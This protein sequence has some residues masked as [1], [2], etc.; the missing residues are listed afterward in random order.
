M[1]FVGVVETIFKVAVGGL[2]AT[3]LFCL[4]DVIGV[5]NAAAI[6]NNISKFKRLY[7]IYPRIVIDSVEKKGKVAITGKLSVKRADFE[8]ELR[9]KGY[10]PS[11][12][13]TKDT[14]FLI[15]DDPS[16]SSSKNKAA[17]KF[18]IPKIT[19]SEFRRSYLR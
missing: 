11:S 12:S 5:A 3:V 15:T 13:V 4:P 7:Y 18:G 1:A 17:D 14:K 16:S 19:E 6:R 8:K 2:P 9:A 10:E